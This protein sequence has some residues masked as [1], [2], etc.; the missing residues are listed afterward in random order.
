MNKKQT[1]GFTAVLVSALLSGC[2]GTG[3][4]PISSQPTTTSGPAFTSNYGVVES[5]QSVPAS[6]TSSGGIAGIG[7]GTIAGGVV[8]G[9]IGSQIGEGQGK[10]AATAAGA[11]GGALAGRHLEQRNRAQDMVYQIGVRL[12]NGSYQVVTQDN[13]SNINVGSRVRIENNTAYRY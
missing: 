1:F 3:T 8:G 13:I 12:D 4:Q 5:I 11:I 7:V 6:Q 9:V 2:A 10:T